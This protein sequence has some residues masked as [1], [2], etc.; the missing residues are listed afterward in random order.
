MP[1]FARRGQP[2]NGTKF[3]ASKKLLK[4]SQQPSLQDFRQR[5]IRWISTESAFFGSAWERHILRH[6]GILG[7]KSLSDDTFHTL[8]TGVEHFVI[9]RPLTVVSSDSGHIEPLTPNNF[10]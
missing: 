2:H 5:E 3:T 1:F 4:L 7:S 6:L 10:C 8:L 9:N